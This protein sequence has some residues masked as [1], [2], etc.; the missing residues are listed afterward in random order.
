MNNIILL[1]NIEIGTEINAKRL[2][3]NRKYYHIVG[4]E[5]EILQTI[6]L[7][8]NKKLKLNKTRNKIIFFENVTSKN[9]KVFL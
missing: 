8:K 9:I 3:L 4:S 5:I 2:K 1:P 6:N 7:I